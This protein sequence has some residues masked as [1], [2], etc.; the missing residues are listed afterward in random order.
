LKVE[1]PEYAVARARLAHRPVY[2]AQPYHVTRA[3]LPTEW[4]FTRGFASGAIQG[5]TR[6][7]LE[8]LGRP[9]GNTQT[10]EPEEGRSTI[11]SFTLPL[12]DSDG[13]ILRYLSDPR[14]ALAHE[15]SGSLALRPAY[16]QGQ[17]S[18]AGYPAVGTLQIGPERIRYRRRDDTT[19]RFVDLEWAVDGTA[20]Q[21]HGL[22]T[23]IHNGEQ[24]R[25]GQRI[26]LLAGYRDLPESSFLAFAR[27]EITGVGL[28]NDA[29]TYTI[30]AADF[31]RFLRQ[32]VFPATQEA[33]I[34]IQGHPLDIALRMLLSTG[35]AAVSTGTVQMKRPNVVVGIG[36]EFLSFIRSGE[37]LVVAPFTADDR[38]LTVASVES[39]TRL[40]T[41]EPI[42]ADSAVGLGYRRA[43]IAGRYDVFNRSWSVV[44]PAPFVDIAGIEALRDG[45][46]PDTEMHFRLNAP[47]DGKEFIEREIFKPL[48]LFPFVTQTGAYSAK[49]S[50]GRTS[51]PVVTLDED[52]IIG[53]AWQGGEDRIINQV[54][55]QYDWNED[56]APNSFGLRQRY[57]A[58]ASIEKYGRKPPLKMDS[59]GLH[60]D[61]DVQTELDR[62]AFETFQRFSEPPPRLQLVVRYGNHVVD[63]GETVA[64]THKRIPD[65]QSGMRGLVTS[66][67]QVRDI[68]PLFGA[69][70]KVVM[71]LLQVGRETIDEPIGDPIELARTD[72]VIQR[73][74]FFNSDS[75]VLTL[76]EETLTASVTV[77]LTSIGD[78]LHITG[79]QYISSAAA[80]SPRDVTSRI[81]VGTLTGELLDGIMPQSFLHATAA[82]KGG[83]DTFARRGIVKHDVLY[84]PQTTGPITI[85]MTGLAAIAN[86]AARDRAL[87]VTVRRP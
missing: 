72:L 30:S 85:L 48:N 28:S 1:S 15:L 38:V 46:F 80:S 86:G 63:V 41:V 5:A 12:Q 34:E 58:L 75:V 18:I 40:Y 50:E 13:E 79:R 43:G 78:T 77:T 49:V 26:Q 16:I 45:R 62:W 37:I 71:T 52:Q 59:K 10:V 6:G 67:F 2:I 44:A 76:D 14:V 23:V 60:T 82:T 39:S 47:E 36:T 20:P 83:S 51:T 19:N 27:M 3:G 24:L 42:D 29:V 9:S 4:P 54:E 61:L 22:N 64:V 84:S 53:W 74:A 57:S 35:T 25:A 8:V 73:A 81:R 68:R 65:V 7:Y 32:V 31:Q 17:T 56:E 21:G 70:G 87:T 55:V 69:E 33:I 11:G 66:R